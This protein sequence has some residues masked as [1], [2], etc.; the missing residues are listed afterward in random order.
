MRRQITDV[1]LS[2]TG[3]SYET[4]FNS[5]H[6]SCTYVR[7][8]TLQVC[9]LI[10]IKASAILIFSPSLFFFFFLLLLRKRKLLQFSQI[11]EINCSFFH[12]KYIFF[13]GALKQTGCKF[14]CLQASQ[15]H[16]R[17]TLT[18]FFSGSSGGHFRL[19]IL[20]IRKRKY[21]KIASRNPGIVSQLSLPSSLLFKIDF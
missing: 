1:C 16:T 20:H 14:V 13:W 15:R 8:S 4:M 9:E 18:I 10:I 11:L 2:S 17:H 12:R 19:K 3:P 21:N 6:L 7:S 5:T